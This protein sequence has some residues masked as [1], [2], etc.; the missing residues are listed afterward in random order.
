MPKKK[1]S[2]PLVL[3]RWVDASMSTD[4]HWQEGQ[5]PKAPRRKDHICITLGFLTHMDGDFVQVTQTITSDSHAH[6]CNIPRLMVESI[7]TLLPVAPLE[8]EA[9]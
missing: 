2:A 3:V 4:E 8:E 6:V 9:G 7:D 5:Q 1:R